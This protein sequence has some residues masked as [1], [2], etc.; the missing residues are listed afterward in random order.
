M[1]SN[2]PNSPAHHMLI[3]ILQYLQIKQIRWSNVQHF[4]LAAFLPSVVL[5]KVS[6]SKYDLS[7][8]NL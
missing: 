3:H 6:I 1:V 7:Q 4:S 8:N 5:E 2:Q